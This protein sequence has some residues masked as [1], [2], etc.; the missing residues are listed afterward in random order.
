MTD[1]NAPWTPEEIA[2]Y[3]D[4]VREPTLGLMKAHLEYYRKVGKVLRSLA[5]AGPEPKGEKLVFDISPK[6]RVYKI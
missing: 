6:R 1:A 2:A 3:H 4:G 5:P